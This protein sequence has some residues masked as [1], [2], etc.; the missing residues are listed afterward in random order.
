VDTGIEKNHPDHLHK[1]FEIVREKANH[2]GSHENPVVPEVG[3]HEY[4]IDG[5]SPG[6]KEF[7]E[8]AEKRHPALHSAI[9]TMSGAG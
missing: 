3:G 4:S 2:T 9:V 6:K 5:A 7:M 8:M 1:L